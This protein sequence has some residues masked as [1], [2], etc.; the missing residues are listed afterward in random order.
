MQNMYELFTDSIDKEI[1]LFGSG[2]FAEYY[3]QVYGRYRRPIY[4]VDNNEGLWKTEKFGLIIH[5]PEVLRHANHSRL[6]VIVA[7]KDAT[8]I[9]EQL[10]SMGVPQECIRAIDKTQ[11]IQPIYEMGYAMAIVDDKSWEQLEYLR[12]FA[13]V[14]KKFVLG[15]PDDVIMGRL[16]TE[17]RGY[18][19]QIQTE[20]LM[21]W[22]WIDHVVT[23]DYAHLRYP[24]V[25]RE[26]QFD[27]CLYGMYY[28]AAFE[29]DA[30][31]F[32]EK[33]VDFLSAVPERRMGKF[34]GDVLELGLDN[35]HST[36]KIV[37]YGTGA[38]A[39]MFLEQYPKC[40][41]AYAI[42][43]N[44]DRWGEDFGRL[45]IQPPAKLREEDIANTIVIFCAKDTADMRAMMHQYGD[46]N[47]LTMVYRQ[48][49]A[50]PEMFGVVEQDEQAYIKKSHEILYKLTKEFT[51]VCRENNLHY[52]IICGSLI[53][54]LRHHDLVPWDDDIDL[55]MPR[56]DYNKLKKIAKERWNNDTF[57]FLDYKNLGGGAFLDCMPRLF[58]MKEKLP[59]KVFKKVHGR[60]TADV[61][62]RIFLDI[63]VMDNAH[64]NPKKHAFR[65]NC[66]KGIY[67]LC[68]GHR[69]V[70]DYSE[71][72]G[73]IPNRTLRLMKFLHGVGGV[74]PLRFLIWMYERFSQ[75][76][77][78]N[79]KS[80]SY[81]MNACAIVCIERTFKHEFFEEGAPGKLHGM[82]VRVP[83]DADGLF[84]AMGYGGLASIMNYPPY[85]IRKPSHYFNCDI[86]IWR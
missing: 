73:Y 3:M 48:E 47:Y 65:T 50:L 49:M 69:A 6:R 16:F 71:Y 39:K 84:H 24:T 43:S 82:D 56:E 51:E 52:Y 34:P 63:Y 11:P 22:D 17:A 38:Y 68:M 4:L 76:A 57:K 1:V 70:L 66:M 75:S 58:Y 83:K 33:H 2:R 64:P 55:A 54:V 36:K 19:A 28:S 7:I 41:P 32:H 86:E 21:Q 31:Y 30:T 67:N 35:I 85:S 13:N 74:L 10:L 25:H 62:D 23:L 45:K 46:F 60:A 29:S 81:F 72:E 79:P 80:D 5:N 12:N 9:V 61:E 78:R 77:N 18:N 26:L 27:A 40:K 20:R 8:P 42:D 14:C 15:I 59:T 37:L 53:G 44:P